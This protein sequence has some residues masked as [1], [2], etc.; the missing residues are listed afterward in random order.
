MRGLFSKTQEKK[1]HIIPKVNSHLLRKCALYYMNFKDTYIWN[2]GV[3]TEF[4][5]L[6]SNLSFI[7]AF[8]IV[9]NTDTKSVKLHQATVP[10][11]PAEMTECGAEQQCAGLSMFVG[12]NKAQLINPQW[13]ENMV[14]HIT[15][16][17]VKAEHDLELAMQ[18]WK[19]K[20]V[21]EKEKKHMKMSVKLSFIGQRII[22]QLRGR[23][24]QWAV[25]AFGKTGCS[26]VTVSCLF[27]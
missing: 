1:G 19:L 3:L 20:E 18:C 5:M 4:R 15:V 13:M 21:S 14:S 6:G 8:C 11:A 24:K 25:E 9:S 2:L 27:G 12:W 22:G 23:A 16:L 17:Y 10:P 26:S 7:F